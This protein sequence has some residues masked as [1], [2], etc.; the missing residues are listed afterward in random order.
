MD[1]TD[2]PRPAF[3]GKASS[4]LQD[5]AEAFPHERVSVGELL[6]RLEGRADGVLLLILALPMCIPNLPGI[7]TIFG[8]LMLAPA[9]QM[10]LG[11]RRMWLPER[12]R[13]WT[14]PRASL[15]MTITRTV[16]TLRRLEVLIRPR[17]SFLTR[18]PTTSYIGIQ[19]LI[20]AIILILPIWGA[21]WPPGMTVAITALALLQRDGLLLLLSVPAALASMAALYFFG[22]LSVEVVQHAWTW[23]H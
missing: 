12:A 23:I 13:R 9:F 15:N 19:T 5:L 4:M 3:A 8:A 7:S 1:Q 11:Q 20:M 2:R 10:M 18:W 6:D 17:L 14:F 22:L 16:P 21:N